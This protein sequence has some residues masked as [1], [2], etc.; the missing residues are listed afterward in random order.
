MTETVTQPPE[1]ASA[2][3]EPAYSSTGS[4]GL[5]ERP[6]TPHDALYERLDRP[7]CTRRSRG[8]QAA[9]QPQR[10]GSHGPI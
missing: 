8:P 6:D 2:S 1:N 5:H 4:E 3:A 10:C 9:L 7:R